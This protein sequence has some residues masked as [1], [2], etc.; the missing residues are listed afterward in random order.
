MLSEPAKYRV[1]YDIT[2]L[3]VLQSDPMV[4]LADDPTTCSEFVSAA[5]DLIRPVGFDSSLPY[6]RHW[7]CVIFTNMLKIP[8]GGDC[9]PYLTMQ[10]GMSAYS[11]PLWRSSA[12]GLQDID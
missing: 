9:R 8:F 2:D 6:Y 10:S 12:L 5:V 7:W 4:V 11:G 1:A 3:Q